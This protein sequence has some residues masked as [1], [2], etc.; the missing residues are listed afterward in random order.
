MPRHLTEKGYE[1]EKKDFSTKSRLAEDLVKG[2]KDVR[3]YMGNVCFDVVAYFKHLEDPNTITLF[4]L[5]NTVGEQWVSLFELKYPNKRKWTG[6]PII[7]S[8]IVLFYRHRDGKFFHA[9]IAAG[10][11]NIRAINS[12]KLGTDWIGEIDMLKVLKNEQKNSENKELPPGKYM[13]DRTEISV[14]LYS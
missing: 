3:N 4:D 6:N 9:A 12:I 8:T 2:F 5:E 13:F 1:V 7:S 11:H 14:Y 10:G